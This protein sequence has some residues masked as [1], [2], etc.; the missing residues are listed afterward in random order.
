MRSALEICCWA[1]TMAVIRW[2]PVLGRIHSFLVWVMDARTLPRSDFPVKATELVR[3]YPV[4]NKSL[5]LFLY[6]T[7]GWQQKRVP[8]LRG[9]IGRT[10]CWRR[11][12]LR[13]RYWFR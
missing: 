1:E 5:R 2:K 9:H 12:V 4:W 3:V 11:N 13:R 10:T 7:Q 6:A 8:A